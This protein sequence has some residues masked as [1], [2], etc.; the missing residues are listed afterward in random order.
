MN[1]LSVRKKR[2]RQKVVSDILV[3]ILKTESIICS[4][5]ISLKRGGFII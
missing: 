1:Q 2:K 4:V 5:S 3:Y